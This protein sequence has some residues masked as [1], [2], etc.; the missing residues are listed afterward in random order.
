MRTKGLI[1]INTNKFWQL[2]LKVTVPHQLWLARGGVLNAVDAHV[3]DG[4]ARLD[5][6]PG[7]EARQPSSGHYDVC[8]GH[9]HSQLLRWGVPVADGGGGVQSSSLPCRRLRLGDFLCTLSY[10]SVSLI[11]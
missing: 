8:C 6:V 9:K 7:D 4:T 1:Y 5:H 3:N 11:N 2:T 10:F